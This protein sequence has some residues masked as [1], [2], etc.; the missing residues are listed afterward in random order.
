LKLNS[1]NSNDNDEPMSVPTQKSSD[2]VRPNSYQSIEQQKY[3]IDLPSP[4]LLSS[5]MVL[6]IFSVGTGFDL[7]GM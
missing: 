7:A 4:L 6:A 5:S 3:P 1:G 2:S